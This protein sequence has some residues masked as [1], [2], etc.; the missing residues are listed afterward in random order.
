MVKESSIN[1]PGQYTRTSTAG[2]IPLSLSDVQP[3]SATVVQP[4]SC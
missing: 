2:R 1:A 3:R 4:S